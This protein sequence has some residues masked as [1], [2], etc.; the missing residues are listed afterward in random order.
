MQ[1]EAAPAPAMTPAPTTEQEI[2]AAGQ[3]VTPANEAVPPASEQ[4]SVPA[5]PDT[6]TATT[7][8]AALGDQAA[9]V[10]APP[11][12]NAAAKPDQSVLKKRLQARRAK[13][14]RRLAQRARLAR[15][16]AAQQQAADPFAQPTVTIRSR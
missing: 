13:E 11:P 10:E 15:Q 16:A 6:G 4:A 7:R 8:L 1:S 14:R 2:A 9:A 12:V 5:S 3:V